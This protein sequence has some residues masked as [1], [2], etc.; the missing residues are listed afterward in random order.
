MSDPVSIMA[1]VLAADVAHKLSSKLGNKEEVI[2]K[3]IKHGEIEE[4]VHEA[5]KTTIENIY[6]A[7]ADLYQNDELEA[8]ELKKFHSAAQEKHEDADFSQRRAM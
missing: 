2:S 7:L 8:E 1:G 5:D 4:A 3:K 6:S